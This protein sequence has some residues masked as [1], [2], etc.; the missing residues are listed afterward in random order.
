M[1]LAAVANAR[2]VPKA[3]VAEEPRLPLLMKMGGPSPMNHNHC[4]K[5]PAMGAPVVEVGVAKAA[6]HHAP[7]SG[8]PRDSE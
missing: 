4:K 1:A 7:V 3:R 8:L 5:T 6:G 2:L